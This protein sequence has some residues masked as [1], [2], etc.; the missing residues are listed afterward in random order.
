M[1]KL[2][3]AQEETQSS[4][5]AGTEAQSGAVPLAVPPAFVSL[6]SEALRESGLCSGG[7]S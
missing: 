1:R 7:A 2:L 4:G 3:K 5:D 6:P